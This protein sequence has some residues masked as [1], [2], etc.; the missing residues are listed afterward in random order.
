MAILICLVGAIDAAA[1]FLIAKPLL[2]CAIIPAIIPILTPAAIF[3]WRSPKS[4]RF[5]QA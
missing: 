2:W 4:P 1:A 5:E 3:S